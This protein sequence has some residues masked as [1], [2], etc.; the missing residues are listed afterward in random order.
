MR[1]HTTSSM[2]QTH[3]TAKPPSHRHCR[4]LCFGVIHATHDLVCLPLPS[5]RPR[6]NPH[7]E[8][9]TGGEVSA[10]AQIK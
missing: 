1:A 9:L 3:A 4:R 7:A 5:S 10:I 2:R 6:A 8:R